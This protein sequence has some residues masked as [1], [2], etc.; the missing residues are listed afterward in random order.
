MP[1]FIIILEVINIKTTIKI[2]GDDINFTNSC[3]FIIRYKSQFNVDYADDILTLNSLEKGSKNYNAITL[4]IGYRLIWAM[5][6]TDKTPEVF[7]N[8]YK[9]LDIYSDDFILEDF[10]TVYAEILRILN[11]GIT[12]EPDENKTDTDQTDPTDNLLKAENL[13]AYSL[14]CHLTIDDLYKLPLNLVTRIINNYMRLKYGDSDGNGAEENT[15]QATQ[16]D[17]NKFNGLF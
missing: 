11:L 3:K 10:E 8:K 14:I 13:I 17:F 12:Q 9:N 5:C 2:N 16:A 1:I 4:I 15:R 7:Y 6:D